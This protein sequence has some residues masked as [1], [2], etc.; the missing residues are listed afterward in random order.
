MCLTQI[1]KHLQCEHTSARALTRSA[2]SNPERALAKGHTKFLTSQTREHK[3]KLEEKVILNAKN[4]NTRI[5]WPNKWRD[6]KRDPFPLLSPWME[7]HCSWAILRGFLD[8]WN[9]IFVSQKCFPLL[10]LSWLRTGRTWSGPSLVAVKN[11]RSPW[12]LLAHSCYSW[13]PGT[14]SC[15]LWLYNFF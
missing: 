12:M 11:P 6:L 15:R 9:S 7:F 13:W 1:Y 4:T 14:P 10:L 3:I 8:R 2:S 5:L